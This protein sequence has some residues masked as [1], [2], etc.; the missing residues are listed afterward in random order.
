MLMAVIILTLIYV[1]CDGVG[2]GSLA[3]NFSAK[4]YFPLNKSF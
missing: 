3:S 1:D 4:I 2:K